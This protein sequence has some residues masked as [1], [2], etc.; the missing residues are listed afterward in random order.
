MISN[1]GNLLKR[2][3]D[4]RRK[5]G[6]RAWISRCCQLLPKKLTSEISRNSSS[7]PSLESPVWHAEVSKCFITASL[8]QYF[9]QRHFI[10]DCV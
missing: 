5:E 2:N 9:L 4:D 1:N 8:P 10:G 7:L 6:T 3:L